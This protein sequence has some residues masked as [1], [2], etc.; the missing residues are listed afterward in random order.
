M[1]IVLLLAGL[2]ALAGIALIYMQATHQPSAPAFHGVPAA[3]PDDSTAKAL[4]YVPRACPV[5]GSDWCAMMN[6]DAECSLPDDAISPGCTLNCN[7]L[8]SFMAQLGEKA[9]PG[10]E[11]CA[12]GKAALL[13]AQTAGSELAG[14]TGSPDAPV[15]E[16]AAG[17][18]AFWRSVAACLL[19][20]C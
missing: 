10:L 17:L 9:W 3:L 4:R 2:A 14:Y 13:H 7:V 16:R 15:S 5:T 11:T 12:I 6:V 18:A 19:A 1:S 20:E 8:K